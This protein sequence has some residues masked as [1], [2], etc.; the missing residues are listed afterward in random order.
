MAGAA[1]WKGFIRF[2]GHAVAVKL[3]SAVR[4]ERVRFHLLHGRDQA[5]LRQQMV[6]Q[7]DRQPVPPEEQVKGFE[8]AEG[9]YLIVDPGELEQQPESDRAIEVHEFVKAGEVDPLFVVRTYLLEPDNGVPGQGYGALVQA[10]SAAGAAGICTWTMR[11]RSFWGAL[12]A[13]EGGLRL[14]ALRYADEV[15]PGESLGL[16]DTAL[17]ERE[18]AIG[19]ELIGRM[20]APFEPEQFTDEHQAKLRELIEKKA[21][22]EAVPIKA[23]R[24]LRPTAPDELLSVLEESLKKAA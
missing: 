12:V 1:V 16:T 24:Q 20:T 11:K 22:G 3:H 21:R 15:V 14:N 13:A 4:E 23:P 9:K 5:R 17:S 2:D 6:C 10:L 18:L 19:T 8:M 7:L